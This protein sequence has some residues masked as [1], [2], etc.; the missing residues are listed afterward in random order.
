MKSEVNVHERP[1]PVSQKLMHKVEVQLLEV[2][3]RDFL[4]RKKGPP[5]RASFNLKAI[6]YLLTFPHV[7]LLIKHM[8]VT[9]NAHVGSFAT[10]VKILPYLRH[11][12]RGEISLDQSTS[13]NR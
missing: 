9:N 2:Q 5:S 7:L 11:T 6:L 10:S 12:A 1:R 8:E 4:T 3:M 13:D